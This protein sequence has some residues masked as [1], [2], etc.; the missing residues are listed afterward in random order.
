MKI[1]KVVAAAPEKAEN[2]KLTG[3]AGGTW[4]L[5]TGWG[6]QTLNLSDGRI[7]F[8]SAEYGPY[9]IAAS[10]YSHPELKFSFAID[11]GGW[12]FEVDFEGTVSGD[13]LE[14]V[15]YPGEIPV[16]GQRISND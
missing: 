8:A 10:S 9:E 6:K 3:T 1:A 11:K 16:N 15:Y 12:D 7:D 5:E 14:G 4:E 2:A 13:T